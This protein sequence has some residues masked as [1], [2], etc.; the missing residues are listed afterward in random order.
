MY[1]LVKRLRGRGIG[2]VEHEVY[3]QAAFTWKCTHVVCSL[4]LDFIDLQ[5]GLSY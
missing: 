3:D 4:M 5:A 2:K 1:V